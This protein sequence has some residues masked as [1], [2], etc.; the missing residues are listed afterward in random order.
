MGGILA[1][2]ITSLIL[3][4]ANQKTRLLGIILLLLSLLTISFSAYKII[5]TE[6][7]PQTIEKH[8]LSEK[9][10]S[11]SIRLII[12]KE[13]WQIIKHHPILG[14]GLRSYKTA[15]APFHKATWMEIFPHPHNL[16]L[17]LWIETSLIGLISFTIL[18]IT[19]FQQTKKQNFLT[20]ILIISP[21]LAILIHGMVDMPYFKND[22]SL[23]FWI[24]ASLS[25]SLLIQK[26][27]EKN[28]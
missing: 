17:M 25:P 8:L 21:L 23:Q 4:I 11:S 7:H 10:W 28:N 9:K 14:T 2:T 20:T 6:L 13:S 5:N 15:I 1:I 18:C 27:Y 26:K 22:L 3:F 19:W 24:L 16:I 12:W